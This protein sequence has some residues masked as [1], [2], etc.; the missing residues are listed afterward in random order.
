[1]E[2]LEA[3][4]AALSSLTGR[5]PRRAVVLPDGGGLGDRR[6]HPQLPE[7][8]AVSLAVEALRR[9]A[10][11]PVYPRQS[12]A[13][14]SECLRGNDPGAWDALLADAWTGDLVLADAAR[15]LND[16]NLCLVHCI[17]S[18]APGTHMALAVR[19][20]RV[21]LPLLGDDARA[22][23]AAAFQQL[24]G[25]VVAALSRRARD[26]SSSQTRAAAITSMGQL[27][28]D[29]A[30][31][32]PRLAD[33]LRQCVG[34]CDDALR[35]FLHAPMADVLA[36]APDLADALLDRA[37]RVP[38]A[39]KYPACALLALCPA[40]VL[41]ERA[42]RVARVALGVLTKAEAQ[43]AIEP[44]LA[45]AAAAMVKAVAEPRSLPAALATALACMSRH[46]LQHA[47]PEV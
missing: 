11:E 16:T 29:C 2:A 9:A 13:L 32:V 30:V 5:L 3:V 23:T 8:P 40:A 10:G 33:M 47:A 4:R 18:A 42:D 7:V 21:L 25:E 26:A 36:H 27:L 43:G 41:R 38:Q 1:M 17:V 15:A 34:A 37:E 44:K 39:A 6:D 46:A 20:A 22:R 24:F 28:A 14:V 45:L 19:A 31:P 12:A 35:L